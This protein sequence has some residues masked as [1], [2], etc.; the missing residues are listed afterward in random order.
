MNYFK[1]IFILLLFIAGCT[2]NPEE[3]KVVAPEI[4]VAVPILYQ[5]ATGHPQMDPLIDGLFSALRNSSTKEYEKIMPSEKEIQ[6]VYLRLAPK[7]RQEE[8][9]QRLKEESLAKKELKIQ[10]ELF[11]LA[12]KR[13]NQQK[14]NWKNIQLTSTT[15][16]S[17]EQ[18]GIKVFNGNIGFTENNRE[19]NLKFSDCFMI[20]KRMIITNVAIPIEDQSDINL[21]NNKKYKESYIRRCVAKVKQYPEMILTPKMS[22]EEYCECSFNTIAKQTY[23]EDNLKDT[24]RLSLQPGNCK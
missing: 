18:R 8:I 19:F 22:P 24:T 12:L 14:I 21:A 3:P 20:E 9:K 2:N 15:I 5:S 1:T 23:G 16:D 6:L 11:E 10:M 17:A 13:G 4:P 7:D